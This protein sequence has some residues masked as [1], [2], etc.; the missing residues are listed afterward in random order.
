M[1]SRKA[2][3]S[4]GTSWPYLPAPS[5]HIPHFGS[6]C[7]YFDTMLSYREKLTSDI[8]GVP[9]ALLG[10]MVTSV[11]KGMC[12]SFCHSIH[13]V[14]GSHSIFFPNSFSEGLELFLPTD[15]SNRKLLPSK[16]SGSLYPFLF[17][18]MYLVIR[19]HHR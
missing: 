5:L 11:T 13:A 6:D 16:G 18:E 4:T 10:S 2:C 19:Y 17:V 3:P 8:K 7:S 14:H 12:G 1:K 15:H 9:D